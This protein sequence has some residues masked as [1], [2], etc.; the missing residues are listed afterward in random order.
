ML[1][2]ASGKGVD[3]CGKCD[4][5]PCEDLK[6]F[7]AAMPHRI[8]LWKSHERINEVGYERWYIEMLEHY[9]CPKCGSINSA[10]DLACRKCGAAPGS[11]Y[12]ALHREEIVRQLAKMK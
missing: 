8:E 12:V 2:C 10:Y 9:S 5:Y 11:A 4:E 1:K 3:F 6:V 7:Q